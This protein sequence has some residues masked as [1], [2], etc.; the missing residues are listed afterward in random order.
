MEYNICLDF[1]YIFFH[2]M[3]I[4]FIFSKKLYTISLR[5]AKHLM[6]IDQ[7]RTELQLAKRCGGQNQKL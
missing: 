3:H 5:F 7:A 2:Y 4:C 1:L 6:K